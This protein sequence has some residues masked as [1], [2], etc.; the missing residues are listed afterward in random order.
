MSWPIRFHSDDSGE[1]V[2]EARVDTLHPFIGM[3]FPASDIPV[4][5]RRLYTINTLRLIADVHDAPVLSRATAM[6]SGEIEAAR[7]R[8]LAMLG[9]DLRDPLQTISMV[10]QLMVRSADA[11]LGP[12]HHEIDRPHAAA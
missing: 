5:A 4:Q 6:R 9:H 2:A 12:A 11:R 8:L 1:V 3:R 7:T 10:G